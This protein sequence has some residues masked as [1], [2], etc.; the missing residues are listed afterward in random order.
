MFASE[1]PARTPF[2]GGDVNGDGVV[3]FLDVAA[4]LRRFGSECG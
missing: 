2:T 3:T 4:V 1:D